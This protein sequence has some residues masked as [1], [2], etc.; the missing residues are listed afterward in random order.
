MSRHAGQMLFAGLVCV[1]VALLGLPA[2]GSSGSTSAGEMDASVVDAESLVPDGGC[3]SRASVSCVVGA[4]CLK[5]ADCSSEICTTGTCRAVPSSCTDGKVDGSETDVDCGGSSCPPCAVPE[6]CVADSDCLSGYCGGG[7]CSP[8]TATDGLVDDGETDV[9]CGGATDSDGSA[10]PASDG[11]PGCATGKLCV[12][13]ADCSSGVCAGATS[14]KSGTCSAPTDTDGVKNGGETGI[15]CGGA[16]SA[17]G[18]P[19]AGSDGAPACGA[20]Q[21][22]AGAI[23]CVSGVCTALV[24]QAANP[25][26]GVK[27]GGETDVDCGGGVAGDGAAP[28]APGKACL[29]ASDCDSKVCTGDVCVAASPTDKVQNGGESDVDCG[30]STTDGAPRCADALR[31]ANDGDCLAGYCSLID[32]TCVDG[33]SCK[34]AV[35]PAAIMDPTGKVDVNGDAIGTPDVNGAGQSAGIDTCGKGEATDPIAQQAHE[36]CC[37]SLLLPGSSTVRL[38]KYEV[39]A[40]R[41]RQFAES[42]SP[43]YDIQDWAKAEMAAGSTAGQTLTAQLPGGSSPPVVDLLPT[44]ADSVPLN[45]VEQLG[46]T[47]VDPSNAQQGCYVGNEAFGA[48][49]YYWDAAHEAVVGSPARPFTQD[50]YDVKSMNCGLYW[51]YAAFCA[52]DGGRLPTNAEVKTAYGTAQYPWGPSFLPSP[53]PYTRYSAGDINPN[54]GQTIISAYPDVPTINAYVSQNGIAGGAVSITVNWLNGSSAN[55]GGNFYNYPDFIH[56]N[57]PGTIDAQTSGLDN[58]PQIAAPGRFLPDVTALKSA[59][60]SGTEGWQDL[61]ANMLELEDVV[62]SSGANTLCDCTGD[63]TGGGAACSC[64]TQSGVTRAT[65]LPG[66]EYEGG[67]WEGHDSFDPASASI[68]AADNGQWPL[69]GQYGKIGFRCA[70]PAEPAR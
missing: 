19:L 32:G 52:W 65:G 4:P 17:T 34:G 18:A 15:D 13:P 49:V 22:C 63:T 29:A 58:S 24:C 61:G 27:N 26:D 12:L 54:T 64:L 37:R 1:S 62:A 35:T 30:G 6:K 56:Q 3:G 21:G 47:V 41:I 68:L 10:N 69:W 51:I 57:P 31:C 45:A 8:P 59:S 39:T 53:Y 7:A 70:R 9:D 11:A 36:S 2:C 20:G 48:S 55:N 23:D 66:A 40:G 42:M 44:S 50:Y 25:T 38:D 14:T 43:P 28:C 5:A 16:T 46:G 33:R 67:S 60:F